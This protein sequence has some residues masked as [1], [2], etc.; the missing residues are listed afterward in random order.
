MR[1]RRSGRGQAPASARDRMYSPLPHATAPP[2]RLLPI[3]DD[4]QLP[5]QLG[6]AISVDKQLGEVVLDDDREI[7][8]SGVKLIRSALVEY[9]TRR[10]LDLTPAAAM[11]A[12]PPRDRR[13]RPSRHRPDFFDAN[14]T[15]ESPIQNEHITAVGRSQHVVLI[16]PETKARFRT[17]SIRHRRFHVE[18]PTARPACID[19]NSPK[20]T[21]I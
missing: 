1:L 21:V 15:S 3:D 17:L 8:R 9:R 2:R 16:L 13:E 12:D 18:R 5:D 11:P 10:D 14:T 6:D 4:G 7:S 20:L 19:T